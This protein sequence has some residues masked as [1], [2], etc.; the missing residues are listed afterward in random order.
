MS[1]F[2]VVVAQEPSSFTEALSA[3]VICPSTVM[4]PGATGAWIVTGSRKVIARTSIACVPVARP[5]VMLLC[6]SASAPISA[7]ES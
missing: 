4:E 7:T 3:P 1:A 2:S 5:I 6:P